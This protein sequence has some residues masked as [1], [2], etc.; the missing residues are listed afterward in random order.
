MSQGKQLIGTAQQALKQR[1]LRQSVHTLDLKRTPAPVT[2]APP[3]RLERPV[4]R[5]MIWQRILDEQ[6]HLKD[7]KRPALSYHPRG[8]RDFPNRS[9]KTMGQALWMLVKGFF[10]EH[11]L[12]DLT[13]LTVI[14][15]S[16]VV[17]WK[18]AT[19]PMR[20]LGHKQEESAQEQPLPAL[21]GI[22]LTAVVADPE[23]KA[24]LPPAAPIRYRTG[25][26]R[27]G[28]ATPVT[29]PAVA[30]A[31]AAVPAT[32][33]LPTR[34][35]WS[36]QLPLAWPRALAT[37][38]IA[39]LLLAAGITVGPNLIR[40]T[41]SGLQTTVAA[42]QS[43]AARLLLATEA[44]AAGDLNEAQGAFAAAASDFDTAKSRLGRLGLALAR[45]AA[46]LPIDSTATN[47]GPLLIVGDELAQAGQLLA[48]AVGSLDTDADPL[49]K[50]TGLR[51]GLEAA[52][53]H[54]DRAA[55]EISLV[56]AGAL[57]PDIQG[58][59]AAAQAELPEAA[60]SARHAA[61]A[62]ALL[63]WMLGDDSQRRYLIIF[64]N[65]AELRATG[66]FIGSFAIMDLDRGVIEKIEIPGGGSYDLQGSLAARLVSPRPLHLVRAGW[67]FQDANWFADYPT[68]AAKLA[69]FLE[70]SG[71]PSVDGVIALNLRLMEQVLEV[72]GPIEMP[73]YNKTV[74]HRNFWYETQKQVELDYDRE[75]NKPKQFIADMAPKLIDRLLNADNTQA[76]RLAAV[77]NEGLATKDALVWL[78]NPDRELD[79]L[80][81]GW[82]GQIKPAE[83]DYL[84]IVHS[85]IAGQK[86]DLVMQDRVDHSVQV[87]ADGSA[88]VTL[89]LERT[90][91]G[92]KDALF[93]GVR[94]VDYVRFLVP[95]GSQLIDGTGF[96]APDPKL[97]KIPEADR[98][99]DPQVYAL[100]KH[101]RYDSRSGLRIGDE[102]GKTVFG[103]WLQTDPGET[104]VATLVYRLPPNTVRLSESASHLS[105]AFAELIGSQP[106][107]ELA[108]SY[109]LLLQ[110]QP[111][112]N[113]IDFTSR[114]DLPRGYYPVY[115]S[116]TR[117]ED[118]RGRWQTNLMLDR[119]TVF[120]AI[121]TAPGQAL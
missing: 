86:T 19:W 106:T 112:A 83:G 93:T 113:P 109:S 36:W 70:K 28:P 75:E 99:A 30:A 18:A 91:T 76:M 35:K 41:G 89:T 79:A 7:V 45:A 94:N 66:G 39:G 81:L 65:N 42:A 80:K 60:A 114:L 62:L 16:A 56:S 29:R 12:A 59:V 55:K 121:A 58:P 1:P 4:S 107:G 21:P 46:Y 84:S 116:P 37:V 105:D 104:S 103:G 9:A 25:G 50:V 51:T 68:S 8:W 92:T 64:Q 88:T 13:I 115:Q 5:R 73:E 72:T 96:A 82:S 33:T 44:A 3:K 54:L 85:N 57:P 38:T 111:G 52:L 78:R 24:P 98:E 14:H 47:A 15:M 69:W 32:K 2:T 10:Q 74:D 87:M 53:P 49:T 43:G 20:A 23:I 100:E 120:D 118:D 34:T 11:P 119:D 27:L 17:I 48:G 77:M 6:L 26:M 63:Q 40:L 101:M 71:G 108:A 97:F 110:K 61:E 102:S 31:V 90:H 95:H 67:E 117:S 22:P